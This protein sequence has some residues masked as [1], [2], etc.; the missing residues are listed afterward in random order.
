MD[1]AV[2]VLALRD[3]GVDLADG[4]AFYYQWIPESLFDDEP[5]L[6]AHRGHFHAEAVAS[7]NRAGHLVEHADVTVVEVRHDELVATAERHVARYDGMA[8]LSPAEMIPTNAAALI[9]YHCRPRQP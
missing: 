6:T 3:R 7:M 5:M 8:L 2:A 9:G 1:G 4:D